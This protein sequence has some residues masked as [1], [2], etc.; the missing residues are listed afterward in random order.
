MTVRWAS[1]SRIPAFMKLARTVRRNRK[2]I[3]TP[4]EHNLSNSFSSK[5]RLINQRGY[6]RHLAEAAIVMV[7]LCCSGPII[8]RATSNL[9]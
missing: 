3:L 6:V 8:E 9:A 5:I 4:V 2:R 7:Y 1:H